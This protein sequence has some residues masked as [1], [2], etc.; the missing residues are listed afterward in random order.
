MELDPG[1]SCYYI[2]FASSYADWNSSQDISVKYQTYRPPFGDQGEDA[3]Q[4]DG[5]EEYYPKGTV[6]HTEQSMW[7]NQ[8]EN[9]CA[10]LYVFTNEDLDYPQTLM[11]YTNGGLIGYGVS[12]VAAISAFML[13]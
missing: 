9:V 13:F 2:T 1:D 10:Y 7:P 3:C 8:D 4:P 11:F 5:P 6:V 12:L